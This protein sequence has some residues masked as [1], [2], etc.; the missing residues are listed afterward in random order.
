MKW[1]AYCNWFKESKDVR[2]GFVQRE[3]WFCSQLPDIQLPDIWFKRAGA[4]SRRRAQ[5]QICAMTTLA[6]Q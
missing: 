3:M 1:N 5:K 6:A 2:R 4:R